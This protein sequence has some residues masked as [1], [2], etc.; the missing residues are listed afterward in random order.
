MSGH[1]QIV[2][3]LYRPL[4]T[5]FAVK[6]HMKWSVEMVNSLKSGNLKMVTSK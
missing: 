6:K 1:S 5:Y 2:Y 3:D 4:Q